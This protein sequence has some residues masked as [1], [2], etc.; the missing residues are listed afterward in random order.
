MALVKRGKHWYG[1]DQAEIAA[2]LR[3]HIRRNGYPAE[4]F[5]DAQLDQCERTC[6]HDAF[7]ATTGVALYEGSQDVR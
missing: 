6:G 5:A 3:R 1:H 2:E 4:H 7:E